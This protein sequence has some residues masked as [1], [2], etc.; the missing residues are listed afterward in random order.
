MKFISKTD[1]EKIIRLLPK[2]LDGI[3]WKDGVKKYEASRQ[4]KLMLEKWNRN[5]KSE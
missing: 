2:V 1:Y 5:T 4:L 3:G